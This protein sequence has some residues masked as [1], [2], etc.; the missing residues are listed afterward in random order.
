[1]HA[2]LRAYVVVVTTLF[3]LTATASAAYEEDTGWL[4]VQVVPVTP[5]LIAQL[6][7]DDVG[8]VI[9]NVVDD[10]PADQ[11]G[12][13]QWDVI[14]AIDGEPVPPSIADFAETIRAKGAK[15]AV[16]L[17]VIRGGK[18]QTTSVTL[19]TRP[20]PGDTKGWLYRSE[21]PDV[22]REQFLTQGHVLMQDPD[23]NWTHKDLSSL[24][25]L[26]SVPP[27][28]SLLLRRFPG[29]TTR[30]F[31]G[32]ERETIAI[33]VERDGETI[34]VTRDDGGSITVRRSKGE[35]DAAATEQTYPDMD[36]LKAADKDAYELL[37]DAAGDSDAWRGRFYFGGPPGNAYWMSIDRYLDNLKDHLDRAKIDIGAK[38]DFGTDEDGN[39]TFVVPK[40]RVHVG[41]GATPSII[42]IDRQT[43]EARLTFRVTESGSIEVTRRR[44]SEELVNVYRDEDDLKTRA[45]DLYDR[46]VALRTDAP[47]PTTPE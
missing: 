1:M 43:N 15:T 11:A 33:K 21:S 37:R 36:A 46:Y 19:A 41:G 12:L 44:G 16:Q 34:E 42:A 47:E 31:R 23:G 32:D 4:G 10:S 18:E 6:Q 26:D 24:D 20:S 2:Y 27:N 30:V 28:L 25:H 5:P 39:P 3:V 45:P 9:N 29:S 40:P 14:T 38:L 35:D 22:I 8:V 17:L 7:L 13:K